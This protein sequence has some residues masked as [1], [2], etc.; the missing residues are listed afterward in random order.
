MKNKMDKPTERKIAITG[1]EIKDTKVGTKYV[2][3]TDQGKHEFFEKKKDGTST[4]AYE[5]W[6]TFN[7]GLGMEVDVGVKSEEVS[8][9]NQEGKAVN[10]TRNT[11]LYFKG[12]EHG[13][14]HPRENAATPKE[15]FEGMI[16]TAVEEH[17][18]KFHGKAEVT[19][20]DLPF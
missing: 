18:R 1:V 5:Q 2:L 15:D 7:L 11:I 10:F 9:T 12:D 16:A 6:S 19:A 8:F 4:K 14:P 17:E 13:V 20:E 3:E